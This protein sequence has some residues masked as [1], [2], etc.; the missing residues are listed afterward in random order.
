MDDMAVLTVVSFLR[1]N[2]DKLLLNSISDQIY[3]RALF[4]EL[5]TDKASRFLYLNSVMSYQYQVHTRQ[6]I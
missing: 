6:D 1:Q 3:I 2:R 4:G 5:L